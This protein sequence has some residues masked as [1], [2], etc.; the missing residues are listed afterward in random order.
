MNPPA[1]EEWNSLQRLDGRSSGPVV[2]KDA[3]KRMACEL[4]DLD[5]DNHSHYYH[6]DYHDSHDHHKDSDDNYD[7][8]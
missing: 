1:A 2:G 3:K 6:G 4:R 8:Y 5:L 7:N